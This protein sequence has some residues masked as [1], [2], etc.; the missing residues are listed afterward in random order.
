MEVNKRFFVIMGALLLI[1]FAVGR[2]SAPESVK[3]VKEIATVDTKQK[4]ETKNVSTDS[5]RDKT[6][7]RIT[8]EVVRPDGTRETT[9]RVIEAS[10]TTRK[11]D[12]STDSREESSST[13][14]Q[15]ESEETVARR[16]KLSIAVLLGS[17]IEF[18]PTTLIGGGH[19]QTNLIG[20]I[21]V[22]LWGLS[23]PAGGFSVGLMF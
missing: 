15:K 20:P 9:T 23:S 21:T 8:T 4:E 7:E 10:T 18:P 22:G 13:R 12:S 19:I 5:Q 17:K 14:V 11:R 16:S 6:V 3:T 1:A 2:W